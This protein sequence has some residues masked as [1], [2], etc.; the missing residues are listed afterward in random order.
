MPPPDS[1]NKDLR[2]EETHH[3]EGKRDPVNGRVAAEE[4]NQAQHKNERR[5]ANG[6]LRP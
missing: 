4:Q 1:N 5:P 3:Q 6:C 2:H